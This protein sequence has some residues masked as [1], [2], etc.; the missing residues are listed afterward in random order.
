MRINL[1]LELELCDYKY[2]KR[3]LINANTGI[4]IIIIKDHLII[5][6]SLLLLIILIK[7][8]DLISKNQEY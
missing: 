6:R 3:E 1:N 5:L 8:Y 4:R 2:C 7:K